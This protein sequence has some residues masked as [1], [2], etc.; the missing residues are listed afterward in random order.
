MA[1]RRF[2]TAALAA[3]A[4]LA[5][6]GGQV[7]AS[8]QSLRSVPTVYKSPSSEFVSVPVAERE[9]LVDQ[10]IRAQNLGMAD[11][12]RDA[13]RRLVLLNP[14]DIWAKLDLLRYAVP[15]GLLDEADRLRRSLCQEPKSEGCRHATDYLA[16]MS[17]DSGER[18]Q[19]LQLLETAGRFDQ[20]I[21][22][23]EE[24]FGKPPPQTYWQLRYY[25]MMLHIE[26]RIEEALAALVRLQ[27][28][29]DASAVVRRRAMI[30]ERRARVDLY[31]DFGI[32]YI[33]DPRPSYQNRAM[34][35][36]AEALRLAPDD[37]R[38][39]R[40]S[41]NLYEVQYWKF[42]EYGDKAFKAGRYDQAEYWY[43][44]AHRLQN[45]PY[46]WAGLAAVA[47]KRGQYDLAKKF[48]HEAIAR[49]RSESAAEQLRLRTWIS[50]LERAKTDERALAAEKEGRW[51]EAI[52]LLQ[53]SVRLDPENAWARFRL[54]GA[55]EAAGRKAE[56]LSAFEGVPPERF[57]TAEWAYPYALTL[58]SLD[59]L[60]EALEALDAV[61]EPPTKNMRDLRRTVNSALQL[62]LADEFLASGQKQLALEA[63]G[64][65]EHPDPWV[66]MKAGSIAEEMGNTQ[67]ALESYS[68]I[69][70]DEK[71]GTEARV[72]S[73][74]LLEKTGSAERALAMVRE[75][76]RDSR[77]SLTASQVREL[78]GILNRAGRRD[79]ALGLFESHAPAAMLAES[80]EGA[81]YFRDYARVARMSLDA[82]RP[83][84]QKGFHAAGLT[85]SPEVSDEV[86]TAAMRSPDESDGW[87]RESLRRDAENVYQG[88]NVE[89]R[90]G[91]FY[92]RD[93]GSSGYS[94]LSEWVWMTDASVSLAG[95]RLTVRTDT[96]NR[97]VGSLPAG[98]PPFGSCGLRPCSDPGM[99]SDRG[100]ALGIQWRNDT[101]KFN[102][103]TTPVGFVKST[104]VGGVEYSFEALGAGWSVE[105]FRQAKASSLL[106][107][108]GM[109]DPNTGLKWG[110][111]TRTGGALNFS[112]D[113]GGDDGIWGKLTAGVL[114]GHNVASN[115]DAQLMGGYYRRLINR[116]NHEL[117]AG[118]SAMLWH[119]DKDL[120]GYTFGQGGY[121]S[122][123]QY[124][125]ASISLE[126]A[127]RTENWAW[128][129]RG[130]I[131]FSHAK[132]DSVARYPKKGP[133]RERLQPI[134]ED[135]L[136][137]MTESDSS[138]GVSYT[139][140]F[141]L[142]RRLDPHF[143]L[144]LAGSIAKGEGY[145]PR[146]GIVYLRWYQM[147]WNGNL[148]LPVRPM[149]PYYMW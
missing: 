93:P 5:A 73:A 86:W 7:L 85:E 109:K 103:G 37:P 81:L 56:M 44:R 89:I 68:Q 102:I 98:Y 124:L 87:L 16:V 72:R 10:V 114:T 84:S 77:R 106:A 80:D 140:Q 42:L 135:A 6:C 30:E 13:L 23:M 35:M 61:T 48:V 1:K 126:D 46:G 121:Y 76:T 26:P 145:R 53:Q 69:F 90:T 141:A 59:R 128:D 58:F 11:L 142:E 21:A 136:N 63:L 71:N 70:Y 34:W 47:E 111:V 15:A 94:D 39:K 24:L 65:I 143:I 119:Y 122:P 117:T 134:D 12:E 17:G 29:P 74:L 36:L 113:K 4:A 92:L 88:E 116:P 125:S 3:V 118:L 8:H 108:G 105:A 2:L 52:E 148:P 132:T 64:R 97:S 14:A 9:W 139:A 120:S 91:L 133:L 130:A 104:V 28:N 138:S 66:F 127:G 20:A 123:Q 137:A 38:A 55:Y 32:D 82:F 54:A 49:S 57:R 62:R 27:N 31:S 75:L 25:R 67:A 79:E 78:A 41:S 50:S 147:P 45:S 110:G 18:M 115:W 107:Y 40:W 144:G 129:V 33:R 99:K 22:L 112:L 100:Q 149:L 101:W 19:Q 146:Y 95:G 83:I 51:Q 60:E 43:R 131:G 96:V